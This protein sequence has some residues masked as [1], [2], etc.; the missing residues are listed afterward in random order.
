MTTYL[1]SLFAPPTP[2]SICFSPRAQTPVS[3]A[4]ESGPQTRKSDTTH[5]GRGDNGNT[6]SSEVSQTHRCPLLRIIIPEPS[7]QPSIFPSD[8]SHPLAPIKTH[9]SLP[10]SIVQLDSLP[11]T[12]RSIMESDT[13]TTVRCS[14]NPCYPSLS[15]L[16]CASYRPP[17]FVCTYSA[18]CAHA[19]CYLILSCL[20]HSL[21]GSLLV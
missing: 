13:L 8:E 15:L 4:S 3:Q 1:E 14:V 19:C 7:P 9:F 16:P 11:F 6:Q 18:M 2:Q 17:S 5:H 12:P 10:V 20:F 21:V